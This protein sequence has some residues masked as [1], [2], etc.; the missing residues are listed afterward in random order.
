[1]RQ[2]RVLSQFHDRDARSLTTC[3]PPRPEPQV[4]RARA[5]CRRR[6][7]FTFPR[8]LTSDSSITADPASES[9][10]KVEATSESPAKPQRLDQLLRVTQLGPLHELSRAE[11]H[12][13]P[14]AES[15]RRC[16]SRVCTPNLFAKSPRRNRK[17]VPQLCELLSAPPSKRSSGDVEIV[18]SDEREATPL[19]KT[20]H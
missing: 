3:C 19:K 8:P 17:D 15:Q 14:S 11:P 13:H 6:G 1:M 4:A 12:Q 16:E 20:G 10:R 18:L 7:F 2:K 9:F 5:H